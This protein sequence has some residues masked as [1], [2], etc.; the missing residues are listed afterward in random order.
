MDA[1]DALSGRVLTAEQVHG[2][3]VERHPTA[4]ELTGGA[5]PDVDAGDGGLIR[6][7]GQR[8]D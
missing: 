7:G 8:S 5:A 2:V 3:K 1:D 4:S 6:A